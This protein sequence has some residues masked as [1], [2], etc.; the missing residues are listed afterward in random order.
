M[1]CN[2]VPTRN[3]STTLIPSN[4]K[5]IVTVAIN[6]VASAR[7]VKIKKGFSSLEVFGGGFYISENYVRIVGNFDTKR[8][9]K[10][11]PLLSLIVESQKESNDESQTESDNPVLKNIGFYYDV[12]NGVE[13]IKIIEKP[14][15]NELKPL[16]GKIVNLT[17]YKQGVQSVYI[18]PSQRI[19]SDLTF[20]ESVLKAIGRQ[21]T[22]EILKS[23]FL[24]DTAKEARELI[25]SKKLA[26][27][28]VILIA[29]TY[30]RSDIF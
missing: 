17:F 23:I 1:K 12:V 27:S 16:A 6:F 24:A 15:D 5:N 3:T 9:S 29:N 25:K 14:Y 8:Y 18:I 7:S 30:T 26:E 28:Q 11:V 19:I 4:N 10:H 22:P 20:K 2:Y 21:S 13:Q